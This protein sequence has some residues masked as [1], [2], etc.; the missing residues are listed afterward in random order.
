[1]LKL[2]I[3]LILIIT[4]ISCKSKISKTD[5]QIQ[6]SVKTIEL[7]SLGSVYIYYCKPKGNNDIYRILTPKKTNSC[8]IKIILNKTYKMVLE[9]LSSPIFN[10]QIKGLWFNNTRVPIKDKTGRSSTIYTTYNLEG[11]CYIKK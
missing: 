7:D 8:K 5:T 4:I 9:D 2:N 6:A 1:M 10:S 3:Y 11:L